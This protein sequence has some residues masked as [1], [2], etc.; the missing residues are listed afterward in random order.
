[1]KWM[2]IICISRIRSILLLKDASAAIIGFFDWDRLENISLVF[3]DVKT[4]CTFQKRGGV[5]SV[6]LH[7]RIVLRIL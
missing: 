7:D 3:S 1:M 2:S 6:L 5:L 4:L